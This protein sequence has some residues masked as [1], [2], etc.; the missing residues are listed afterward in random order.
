MK[1]KIVV[2]IKID[3]GEKIATVALIAKLQS[4]VTTM[5]VQSMADML[6][7]NVNRMRFIVDELLAEGVIEKIAVGVHKPN[8]K[9]Y[10]YKVINTTKYKGSATNG[11]SRN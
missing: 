10:T 8:Y 4:M 3:R 2:T 6:D 5:S 11:R 9:R 7:E 1:D